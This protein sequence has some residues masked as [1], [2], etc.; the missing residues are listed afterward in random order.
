[1]EPSFTLAPD[2]LPPNTYIKKPS[3]LHYSDTHASLDLG[4]H[5]L[6]E[7][8]A[9]EVLRKSPHPNVARIL[10]VLLRTYFMTLSQ[11]MREAATFDK[12]LCLRGIEDG[13]RHMH[14]LGLVHNDLNPSNIMMDGNRPVVINFDSCKREGDRLGLKGGTF[15]W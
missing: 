3:I 11:R 2:P 10:A 14:S 15:D 8:E 7:I 6:T 13:V 12:S 9:C 1:M 4:R 5:I